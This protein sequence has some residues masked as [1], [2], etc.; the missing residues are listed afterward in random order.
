MGG[1]SWVLLC[2][3]GQPERGSLNISLKNQYWLRSIRAVCQRISVQKFKSC[4]NVWQLQRGGWGQVQQHTGGLW[5][6]GMVGG[7]A[8]NTHNL[9]NI[10]QNHVPIFRRPFYG[11]LR[12]RRYQFRRNWPRERLFLTNDQGGET[13]AS[14]SPAAPPRYLPTSWNWGLESTPYVSEEK[15]NKPFIV[16]HGF[17]VTAYI[18]SFH[19]TFILVK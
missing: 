8:Q 4:I 3:N 10:G 7:G 6:R 11:S 14:F 17:D 2:W 18:Y 12:L 5:D 15:Y 1:G 13:G 9:K 16:Q 19:Q